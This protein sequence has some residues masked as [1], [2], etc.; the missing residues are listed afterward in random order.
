V[1]GHEVRRGAP[2]MTDRVLLL[3]PSRGMGG[4]IERYAE[5]LESAFAS[6]GI[7]Y[8]RIDLHD[9]SRQPRA[10]AHARVL[11]RSRRQLKDSRMPTRLVV[12]HRALLPATSLLARA[13][14]VT[15]ASVVC[16][17]I[18]IW[19]RRSGARWHIEKRLL[20]SP[21]V[22]VVAVS[23][24]T[25]GAL[26]AVCPATVL[27]PGLS[28]HWFDLLV[29]ASTAARIHSPGFHVV[30]AFRLASWRDKGLPQLL[31]AIASLG[32]SDIHL[33][34]CGS[35]IPPPELQEEV[36]AYS[37]C[38]LMPGL[39]DAELAD[40]LASADLF[41]LATRTRTGRDASGEGFGLVLLEAQVAGTPVIAPAYGGSSGAYIDQLTGIAPTGESVEALAR[42]LDG[43]LGDP[44]RLKQM[45]GYAAEWASV[46]FAPDRYA[47]LAV[48]RL[49]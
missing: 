44:M 11:A 17:G 23:S 47:S 1:T 2:A 4:G 27:P 21:K 41:V 26:S 49:L 30:T 48:A 31:A 8:A 42:A 24:F 6:Q 10:M 39:T 43:L 20:R 15:G 36:R 32:R 38:S 5:S 13:P 46:S 7:Q 28:Q 37:Q 9:G 22:R 18:D 3:T 14:S 16:H 12:T 34:V 35:G 45:G 40:Q 29:E 19:S 33:T 25:S